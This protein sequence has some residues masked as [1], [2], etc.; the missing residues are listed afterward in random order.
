VTKRIDISTSRIAAFTLVELMIGMVVTTL[1]VGALS[2]MMTAVGRGWVASD[3]VRS[4]SNFTTQSVTRIKQVIRSSKQIGTV[5]F[6][7]L[8]GTAATPAAVML[9]RGDFSPDGSTIDGKVQF[10]ELGMI[11]H[12]VGATAATSEL[13]YYKVVFPSTWTSAQKQAADTPALA[14]D[15]IY[16][17]NETDLFKAM[18]NVSYTVLATNVLGCT[19]TRIDSASVTRPELEFQLRTQKSDG[20][21]DYEYGTIAVRSP[22]TLPASQR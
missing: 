5:R 10:S 15:D 16:K 13:R 1:V 17:S 4:S 18:T 14:D 9:W 20:S 19:F 3:S 8:D 12:Y 11:E 2:A 22:T 21:V 7:S 6:G